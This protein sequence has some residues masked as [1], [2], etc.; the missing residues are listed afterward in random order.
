MVG[1]GIIAAALGIAAGLLIDWF[2]VAASKEA[3]PIDTLWDVLI[4]FSV[5]VFVGVTVVVLFSVVKFRMRPGE[6]NLDGPPIHGNTRLEVIW[7]AIP[8]ILLVGLCTYAF[9]VL[10]DVEAA[11]PNPVPVRVVGEQFAWTFYYQRDGKEVA[12]P[13][14]HVPINKQI[15]FTLQSKDVLHDFWVPAFRIKKDAVPGLDVTYTVTPNRI[16]SYPIVCAELCGLGHAVMRS[17]AH[18]DSQQDFDAWLSKLGQPTAP[19]AGGGGGGAAPAEDGK[20]VFTSQ[21]AN[22]GACHKLADAGTNGTIGP[23]LDTV[24]KGKDEAFIKQSIED[25]SAEIA[26]GFQD[27]I[28]PPNFK[29]TL[30][31]AKVDALVKYLSEVTK[32]G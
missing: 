14:L 30:G 1:I 9:I 31:Q 2:P 13:Q 8:A 21:D 4:I 16:G 17:T 23:D 7:T 20:T 11:D 26:P 32:G 18:V 27:G 6:E 15:K 3:K 12:S 28:M 22:C 5:P 19:A 29:D 24:L 25:P 10:E